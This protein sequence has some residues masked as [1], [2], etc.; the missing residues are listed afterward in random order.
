MR[1]LR[2]S[3]ILLT[4]PELA[5]VVLDSL[6]DIED[7]ALLSKMFARL[8]KKYSACSSRN[9]GGDI[10]WLEPLSNA[11]ELVK[12]AQE[13][14]VGVVGGPIKTKFG[15]HLFLITEEEPMG[16]TGVDGYHAS[17]LR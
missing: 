7:K 17:T 9:Q 5:Q 15:Y 16:D 2:A 11:P 3:H 4:T 13:T 12:A 8:A 10:G 6:K 1:S 14:P